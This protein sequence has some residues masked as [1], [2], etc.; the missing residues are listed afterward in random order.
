MKKWKIGD[1]VRLA[2]GGPPMT[3][4]WLPTDA[5]D[6]TIF[7]LWFSGDERKDGE[8]QADSLVKAEVGDAGGAAPE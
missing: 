8:F 7:C 4:N 6:K 2:S 3:V 5:N 1:V